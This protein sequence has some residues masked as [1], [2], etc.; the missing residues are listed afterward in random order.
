MPAK[1]LR[2]SSQEL[3]SDLQPGADIVE[4]GIDVV[5]Q[6]GRLIYQAGG[7]WDRRTRRYVGPGTE[8]HIIKLVGSQVSAAEQLASWFLDFEADTPDRKSLFVC[9]DKRRG[10]KTV[11]IGIALGTFGVRYPR[12][13]LGPSVCALV[14]PTFP[15]QREIHETL[16]IVFPRA[17]FLDRR[18]VY[19]KSENYYQLANGA[20]IWVKS[21]D[22]DEGLKL[23]RFSAVAANEAQQL[24]GRAVLNA[25][26]S[27]I[28]N[29]G[30]TFLA[31]NPPD[32]VK[33]LWAEDMH[34]ALQEVDDAGKPVLGFA[35][36]ID[37]PSEKNELIDQAGLSR[38]G[39]LARIIDPVQAQRDALGVWKSIK[40][41]AYPLY[42]RSA[43]RAEPSTAA[44]WQDITAQVNGLSGRVSDK[45]ELGAGM[46]YQR[47]PWC[48]FVEGKVYQAP[49]GVW[50]PAGSY[51]YVIR[52][53]VTNDI[54]APGGWWTE[55]ALCGKVKEYLDACGRSP[56]HYMLIGDAT[57]HRQGASAEQRGKDSDPSTWSW[58][59]AQ[60]WG[61]EV[62]APIE[63]T[64]LE[65]RGTYDPA[66]TKTTYNNP[67]VSER[68]DLVNRVLEENRLIITHD[69]PNTAE[70]FRKCEAYSDTKKP[71]GWGSHLTDAVGYL[72]YVWE[73]ALI[74]HGCIKA[75]V[76]K[77]RRQWQDLLK[78]RAGSG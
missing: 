7:A 35:C 25:L 51:V 32:S 71:R 61:W 22:R 45:R 60:R 23:G 18:I 19:H 39:A 33:G 73:K 58:A 65:R 24:K 62:H 75:P 6:S 78:A 3:L 55:D 54:V 63:T 31:M 38:F 57:G 10:G 64:A 29:G 44:G 8:R 28:D 74:E 12:T 20:Q 52:A 56:R 70:S 48:A 40:D 9:V 2:R 17:W 30:I 13:H 43:I 34:D 72:I 67:L 76:P 37:F 5:T 47:R 50:V 46:D 11:F 77:S 1:S 14:V 36:E 15:Q 41:R 26:G 42:N 66:K 59:I 4:L 69:C 27:N 53:E 68:L 49:P 21:A 16:E